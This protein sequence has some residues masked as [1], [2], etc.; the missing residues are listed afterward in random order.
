MEDL[1]AIGYSREMAGHILTLLGE[2]DLL[3]AYLLRGSR[4]GCI[5]VC[6][7][8]ARFPQR[9]TRKL[10]A[11]APGCLWC[12]GELSLL[13][14]PMAALVG[15]RDI[16]PLNRE[17]AREAG[18][19]AA[20]QGYTLVSG[21]ARG[22]DRTAQSAC[23]EAG[24]RVISVVADGLEDKMPC[25]SMLYVSEE[26]FD[27]EFSSQR[28]L[29]RNRLIHS[30]GSRTRGAQCSNGHG[31]TWEGTERNL[32][33]RYSPVFACRDGSD[34]MRRL[35]QMGAEL[36]GIDEMGD[37]PGLESREISFLNRL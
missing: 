6:R 30:L 2:E 27:A 4:Q 13:G 25:E 21:N 1:V 23:L 3:E 37:F 35:S 24:G 28:A 33:C 10:G 9:L 8:D 7:G 20:R 31:G 22:A 15:S 18:R 36:I 29:S 16:L 26:D 34:A 14:T 5:P 11:D 19:Q 12:K 17:F 32:R